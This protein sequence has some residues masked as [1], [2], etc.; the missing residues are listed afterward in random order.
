[1]GILQ[2]KRGELVDKPTLEEG[3]P[4]LDETNGNLIIK[5]DGVE[6]TFSPGSGV[7][8]KIFRGKITS[9]EI[10]AT[11]E[12][13]IGTITI[14]P[15]EA[16]GKIRL[17]LPNGTTSDKVFVSISECEDITMPTNARTFIYAV[18]Q[19]STHAYVVIAS[20]DPVNDAVTL[21]SQPTFIEILVYP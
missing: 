15:D 11:L 2:L 4:F 7:T 3:E 1:M 21:I 8:P 10:A 18:G 16:Q 6:K 14:T 5:I 12:N 13:T 17:D 20:Y 19:D 9:L